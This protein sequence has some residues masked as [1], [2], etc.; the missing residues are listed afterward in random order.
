LKTEDMKRM[1]MEMP[2][3]RM[4][5]RRRKRGWRRKGILASSESM[6]NDIDGH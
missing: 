1:A 2:R 5:T 3:R 4:R 6:A